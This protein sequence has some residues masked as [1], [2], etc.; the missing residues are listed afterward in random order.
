MPDPALFPAQA[1]PSSRTNKRA[2]RPPHSPAWGGECHGA[3]L[4]CSQG[5]NPELRWVEP[6]VALNPAGG[7]TA[8][9]VRSGGAQ[10]PMQ[11]PR[12]WGGV[13]S[14][15]PP[16]P[17]FGWGL[18]PATPSPAGGAP[19][20]GVSWAKALTTTAPSPR[21]TGHGTQAGAAGALARARLK[22]GMNEDARDCG[23]VTFNMY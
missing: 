20:T 19:H 22:H 23:L 21:G 15:G 11:R 14:P 4:D 6:Q 9:W 1:G 2:A 17:T 5:L 10:W 7:R 13:S 12:R 3:P 16:P 18:L 8:V